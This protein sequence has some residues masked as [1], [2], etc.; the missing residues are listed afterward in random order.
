MTT[1]LAEKGLTL[2]SPAAAVANYVSAV[3]SGT[4]VWVSGQLPMRD[5]E[6][7]SLGAVGAE[8]SVADAVRCAELCALNALAAVG[9]VAELSSVVRVVRVGVFVSSR[10]GFD[11]HAIVANG[12]SDV[13]IA[14]FGDAGRHA[15]AATGASSLP[16]GA[17]V[18]VELLVE[19]G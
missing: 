15:R 4:H 13:M 11:Q 16:L 1:R 17:P 3:R 7:L 5:G 14:A 12:A 9:T 6:L 8:V 10:P 19:V 18:E 2:P